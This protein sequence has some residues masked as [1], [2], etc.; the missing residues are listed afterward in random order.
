MSHDSLTQPKHE[1]A[2][3]NNHDVK[4]EANENDGGVGQCEP[5][6]N[7]LADAGPRDHIVQLYQDQE[8]LNRAVCRFAAGALANGEAVILVPTLAHWDAFCPRLEA[9]G[10]DVK[11]A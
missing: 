9:A 1:F 6:Q 5:W 3:G 7:L 8:F 10:V 2:D 4:R 11:T